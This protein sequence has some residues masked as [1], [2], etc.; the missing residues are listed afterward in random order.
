LSCSLNGICST[1]TGACTCDVGYIGTQCELFDFLPTPA[2]AA[3][4][5]KGNTSSWGGSAVYDNTSGVWHGYFS[6]FYGNCGV[7]SWE[8]NS[9]IV[10]AVASTAIGPYTKVG[11]AS[12]KN[13]DLG[14]A[15]LSRSMSVC[16]ACLNPSH[17]LPASLSLPPHTPSVRTTAHDHHCRWGW[18]WG[19][20]H[21][22]PR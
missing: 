20:K 3:Y 8:T 6:E 4:N 15:P 18:H 7:L 1:T 12:S 22:T 9:Q 14:A 13:L 2:G 17:H 19:Q 10:H 21:T 11:G 16:L 5:S